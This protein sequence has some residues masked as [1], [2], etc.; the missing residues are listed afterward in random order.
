MD[1][2]SSH[3]GEHKL[4]TRVISDIAK[5]RIEHDDT[6]KVCKQLARLN[7]KLTRWFA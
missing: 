5:G 4:R 1:V 7:D 2:E 6:V 3:M